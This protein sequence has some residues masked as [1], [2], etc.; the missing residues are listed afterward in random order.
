VEQA[1]QEAKASPLAPGF[2]EILMPGERGFREEDRRRR[3]GIPIFDSVWQR[4]RE[5]MAGRGLDIAAV[6]GAPLSGATGVA[7]D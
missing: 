4:L 1:I 2:T 5:L 6:A 7:D 3:E